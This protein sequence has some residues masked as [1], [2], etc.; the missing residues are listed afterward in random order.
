[1]S[2]LKIKLFGGGRQTKGLVSPGVLL[3]RSILKLNNVP[4]PFSGVSSSEW[5]AMR[6]VLSV[7]GPVLKMIELMVQLVEV[8]PAA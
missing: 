7:P 1:L 3:T 4:A 6:R 8:S 2:S 5:A